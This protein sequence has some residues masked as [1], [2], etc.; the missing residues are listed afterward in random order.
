LAVHELPSALQQ[1]PA[2]HTPLQQL[3]PPQQPSAPH[4]APTAAQVAHAVDEHELLQQK[5]EQQSL[6]VA[7]AEPTCAQPG[8]QVPAWHM[9]EQ[10]S[11]KARHDWPADLHGGAAQVP[12]LQAPEQQ[13]LNE[14]H[15]AP[16]PLQPAASTGRP[17]SPPGGGPP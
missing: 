6:L 10:Q 9:L 13:S 3:L 8:A 16:A 5:P 2:V 7:H 17:P 11:L 14:R 4:G 1:E 12:A 15:E